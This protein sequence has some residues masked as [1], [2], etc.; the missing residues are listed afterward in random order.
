MSVK[1]NGVTRTM[2]KPDRRITDLVCAATKMDSDQMR[3]AAFKLAAKDLESAR[4]MF[5]CLREVLS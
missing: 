3:R 2:A 1:R 4:V 5:R